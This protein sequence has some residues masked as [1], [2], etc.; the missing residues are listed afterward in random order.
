MPPGRRYSDDSKRESKWFAREGQVFY[1]ADFSV[2]LE[3]MTGLIIWHRS[4][5]QQLPL[6]LGLVQRSGR[7]MLIF[8]LAMLF[9]FFFAR[10]LHTS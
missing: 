1:T 10:L 7:F 4:S 9:F 2:I 3:Y 8:K 5:Q 6:I